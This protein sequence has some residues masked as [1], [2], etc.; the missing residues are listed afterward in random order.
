MSLSNEIFRIK[1]SEIVFILDDDGILKAKVFRVPTK[2]FEQ[3]EGTFPLQVGE[4]AA[5]VTGLVQITVF[6]ERD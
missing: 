2:E 1:A 5:W 4:S 3:F 6:E